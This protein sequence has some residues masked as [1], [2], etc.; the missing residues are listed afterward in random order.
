MES[1][2]QGLEG[3]AEEVRHPPYSDM[4]V[5]ILT[6]CGCLGAD[7][8]LPVLLLVTCSECPR[9]LALLASDRSHAIC[10]ISIKDNDTRLVR[11]RL[12]L[13]DLAGSESG[14][15]MK[16]HD[17]KRK[18]EGAEINK[19]LLAL[20]VNT[21]TWMGAERGSNVWNFT[22]CELTRDR[23]SMYACTWCNKRH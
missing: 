1:S 21:W 13:V 11:G 20:K 8:A 10:Q 4:L 6:C 2:A 18:R 17:Q 14:V 9:N 16:S 15:D 3:A 7:N 5:S 19:S 23:E 22:S 12:S